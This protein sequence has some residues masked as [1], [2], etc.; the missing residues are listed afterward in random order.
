MGIS[1]S[2]IDKRVFNLSAKVGEN[3]LKSECDYS[4]AQAVLFIDLD[5]LE[6]GEFITSLKQCLSYAIHWEVDFPSF[7]KACAPTFSEFDLELY[8]RSAI[9][10]F[11]RKPI[12]FRTD[13][14]K[15]EATGHIKLT[16]LKKENEEISH[17]VSAETQAKNWAEMPPN[18]LSAEK[19][20]SE[21]KDEA[22]K[23]KVVCEVFNWESLKKK[24]FNLTCAVG[25]NKKNSYLVILKKGTGKSAQKISLVGKGICFDTG[26]LSL[27][28]GNYM[29]DMKFDMSGAALVGATFFAL[30]KTK[31]TPKHDLF[32]L[33]TI[34]ENL[35]G[36]ESIKVD[37]VLT[38]FGG[39]TVEISNT[40]AEG[41]LLLA[42]GISY[43]AKELKSSEIISIAT[44]TGAVKYALGTK[45]AGAWTT[46]D[47]IWEK[48][49][50]TSRYTGD[51]IWRLPLDKI[52]LKEMK[53]QI[54]DLK[55]AATTG[56]AGASRAAT[57]LAEFR[58][59]KDYIHLDIA[60]VSNTE[61]KAKVALAPLLKTLYF[62]TKDFMTKK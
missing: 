46:S 1:G 47:L 17:I 55:N 8:L 50:R 7:S 4:K 35:I 58:E 11:N 60:N 2:M 42:E 40:D 14:E 59:K 38:S 16:G 43:A 36:S 22:K 12:S 30:A 34:S 26:G 33:L 57:F 61:D 39:Q 51:Y 27:K 49:Y 53:S 31:F 9:E 41:R 44:L 13:K 19:F 48:L 54:A 24:G 15:D 29:V 23:L 3:H 6:P 28:T 5:K 10:T 52:Y 18:I 20:V 37:S 56:A 32:A 21:L 62:Y 45:Y 25:Q